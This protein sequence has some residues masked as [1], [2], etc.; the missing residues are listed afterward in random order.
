MLCVGFEPTIPAYE[1]AKTVHGLDRSA[2]VTGTTNST[3]I[4]FVTQAF[5]G[6][7]HLLTFF[8]TSD[9]QIHVVIKFLLYKMFKKS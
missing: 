4:K 9:P 8:Y 2:T 6:F 1:R 5:M 3:V 7:L